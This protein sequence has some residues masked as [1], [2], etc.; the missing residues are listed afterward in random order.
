MIERKIIISFITST[1]FHKNLQGIWNST[2]FESSTAKIISTWCQE[3]FDKY[4]KAPGKTLE[5]IFYKKVKQGLQK[6]L[7]EEIEQ[8]ILPGLS[9]EYTEEELGVE[10]MTE[11]AIAYFSERKLLQHAD[12]IRKLVENNK[13]RDAEKLVLSYKL[14][15]DPKAKL[16]NHI[17]SVE[18]I[19]NK[20]IEKP[21][22]LMSPFL[23]KG[24]TTIIYAGY[25]VGKSLLSISIAYLLGLKNYAGKEQELGPFQVKNPTGCLYL[26][27][28]IGEQEMDERIKQ[29]EWLGRQHTN[30]KMKILSVPEYQFATEDTFTLATRANQLKVIQ[31]LKDN[32][33]YGL[34]VL[35][36]VSTLFGLVEEN[37]N[38]E[39]SNKVNPFLRD[40]RALGVACLLLHHAGKDSKRGLRGAS[41]MGAMAHNIFKLSDHPDKDMDEGEAWFVI[42]KDKTR[43]S[44]FNFK[45]FGIHYYQNEDQSET[46]WDITKY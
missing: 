14:I 2:L 33:T 12:Q 29:F 17:L 24:Q 5:S 11:Q 39:W 21:L 8:D 25:G 22:L 3:Y 44:G 13:L 9:E 16:S 27:G 35:D 10:Y 38:S 34:I 1:E 28:E 23:R 6:D 7:A 19:R 26:D 42:S 30:H 45:T 15:D 46:H 18:E 20:K 40:L 41:A 37:D 43:G 4:H 32:R 31:W 36:S